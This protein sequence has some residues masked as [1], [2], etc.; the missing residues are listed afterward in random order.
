MGFVFG[1]DPPFVQGVISVAS[2]SG[3]AG[4]KNLLIVPKGHLIG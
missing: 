4:D 1:I 3:H 2:F